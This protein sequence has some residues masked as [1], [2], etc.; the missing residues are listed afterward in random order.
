MNHESSRRSL[1]SVRPGRASF[2]A[3][4]AAPLAACAFVGAGMFAM[5]LPPV[6]APAGNPV[7]EAKRVLGKILFF[8]EQLSTANTVSCATCH[9]TGVAGADP[10]LARHPG[11]DGVANTADD[12]LGSPGIIKS[13]ADN[14]YV[15]DAIFGNGSQVTGRAANSIINAAFAP[16]LFW[17]GRATGQFIDPQTGAVA[18]ANGGALESQSVAPPLNDVE[19]AHAGYDWDRLSAKLARV[20]PLDL[21]TGL[22]SDVAAA[23]ATRPDYPELF[24]R[25]FGD[26]AITARRIAFAIATYERTLISDQAPY[27]RFL[28]GQANA[29]TPQQQQGLQAMQNNNCTVCHAPPLFTDQSFRAIGLR[30]PTEDPGRASITGNNADRN[31]FKVPSLRNVGLKRSFMHNGQFATLQQVFGF[32]DRAPGVVQFTDNQDPIMTQV[33]LPPNQGALVD[34]FLRNGLLD[35]RVAN[36]T[37]PF[38]RATLFTA[39]TADQNTLVGTGTAGTGAVTPVMIAQAPPMVG[40]LDFRIGLDRARANATARLGYSTTAPVNGRITPESFLVSSTTDASGTLTFHWPLTAFNAT[41]G[42]VVYVQW[43]VADPAA[44]GG[45]AR[46]PVARIPFFCGSYGCPTACP[47]DIN[48]DGGV[49]GDDVSAFFGAWESGNAVGDFNQDGGVDGSDVGSFFFAWESGC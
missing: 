30:P 20:N 29:L 17:D 39:R 4:V 14:D 9:V 36:Q 31:K 7:T 24:R 26:T 34:D 44:P 37:F 46:S 38:D 16:N 43:L 45:Q 33:R 11:D 6:Q 10:R 21:A 42:T 32:Y 2:G 28:A 27:D 12:I 18:L 5:A 49:D 15:R 23:L 25:A 13:D 1:P 41:G 35:A 8:D 48:Q 47:A 19:M 22:Q 3:A 40:N